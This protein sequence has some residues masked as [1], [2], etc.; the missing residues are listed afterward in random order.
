MT[1]PATWLLPLLPTPLLPSHSPLYPTLSVAHTQSNFQ[2]RFLF[3]VQPTLAA[4]YGPTPSIGPTHE[5]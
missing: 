3:E 2:E 4:F 1:W 5:P